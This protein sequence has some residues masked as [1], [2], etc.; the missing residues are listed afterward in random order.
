MITVDLDE[1]AA[2]LKAGNIGIIPTD[3][4]YGL[5]VCASDKKAVER[6]YKL[7]NR[8][9]KPGTII[10]ASI[11][12]LIELGVDEHH[13]RRAEKLWPNSLSIETPLN[14]NLAYLHQ[15]TGRQALR[16]VPDNNVRALL[17][18]T[19]PLLT[20][21]ANQPGKTTANNIIEAKTYFND[22]VDFYVD[23]GDLSERKPS[24][25]ARFENGQLEV[26]REGAYQ[27][28]QSV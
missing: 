1:A 23:A 7:K 20:S 22:N 21:S 24:T 12:Q 25:I 28:M 27:V 5:A 18:Q 14:D 15:S 26:I 6:F 4:L 8:T 2:L 9:K 3:T 16:I 17:E 19:G 11:E 10:A 13:L